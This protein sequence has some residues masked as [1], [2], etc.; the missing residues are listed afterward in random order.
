MKKNLGRI[1]AALMVFVFCI[2]MFAGCGADNSGT[3][4]EDKE[5][6]TEDNSKAEEKER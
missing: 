1:L 6:Q 3:E 4:T 2:G 5:Q